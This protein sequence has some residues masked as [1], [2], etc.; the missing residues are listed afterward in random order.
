MFKD[1]FIEEVKMLRN[2]G[3]KEDLNSMQVIKKI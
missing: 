2:M 3:Y 1:G